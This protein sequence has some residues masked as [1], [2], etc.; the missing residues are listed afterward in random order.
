M[1]ADALTR[2]TPTL[3][4]TV[5]GDLVGSRVNP[6]RAGLHAH[7]SAVLTRVNEEMSPLVRLRIT[8]ADEYQGVFATVG[9]AVAATLLLRV[10]LLPDTDV[11]HGIGR[12]EIGVLAEEPRVEDGPGWWAARA[13]IEQVEDSE[14]RS[15]MRGVRTAYV[16]SAGVAEPPPD[17][18]NPALMWRDQLISGLSQR[19]LSVLRGLLEGST[20]AEVA[21]RAGISA[22]AVSQRVRHDGLAVIVAGH[23]TVRGVR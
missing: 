8:V 18:V 17:L 19:S 20:Q 5:I 22:S 6:D 21:E 15:A 13:A 10:A 1:P 14:Q 9:E 4:A 12:G 11:R 23:E 16:A 2:T 7:L 3:P